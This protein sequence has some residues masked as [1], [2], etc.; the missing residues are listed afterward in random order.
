MH[1]RVKGLV[2]VVAI[3]VAV[4]PGLAMAN[5]FRPQIERLMADQIE[6]WLTE[7]TVIAAIKAQNVE[8]AGISAETIQALDTQWQQEAAAGSG[9][10][11]DAV[12]GNPLSAFL[13]E[14]KQALDGTVSEIFVMD[15]VGL[16]VGQSDVTSDYW[17]GDEAK[18]QKTY[19]AGPGE[20]FID[21]VEFDDSAE[22]FLSQV[23]ATIVDPETGEAIGAITVGVNVEKLF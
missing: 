6:P 15:N 3:A 1:N 2:A 17:Q 7:P 8:H 13:T 12:L 22:A 11:I 4:S 5:E 10:L 21:D 23:S 14:K 16:N 18:W 20:H 19:A 9:P